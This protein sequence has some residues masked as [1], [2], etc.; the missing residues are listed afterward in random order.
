[1]AVQGPRGE[2]GGIHGTGTGVEWTEITW[3]LTTECD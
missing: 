3:D 2:D 1:M